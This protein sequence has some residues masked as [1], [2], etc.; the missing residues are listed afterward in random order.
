VALEEEPAVRQRIVEALESGQQAGPN[1]QVS[2]W[3][4]LGLV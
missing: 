3:T 2:R 4:V 1:G